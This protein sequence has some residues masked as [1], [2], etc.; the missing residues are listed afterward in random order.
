MLRKLHYL[1]VGSEWFV[2]FGVE[3]KAMRKVVA[4]L[5]WGAAVKL[6]TA[7]DGSRL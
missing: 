5:E 7:R 4:I 6:N 2:C 3:A 1:C